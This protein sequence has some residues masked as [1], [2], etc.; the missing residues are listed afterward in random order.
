ME[1]YFKQ[2]IKQAVKE[3]LEE[4]KT[5]IDNIGAV[6]VKKAAEFLGMSSSWVT[7]NK[8][9]LNFYY[10]DSKIL[11]KVKDLK[12]YLDNKQTY[13]EIRKTLPIKIKMVNKKIN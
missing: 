8:E 13:K 4:Q 9:K 6:G 7:K 12:D 11:F 3:V 10:E 5:T 1:E 2:L